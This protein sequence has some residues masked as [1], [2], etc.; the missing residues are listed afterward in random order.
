MR[1]FIF[2]I[3]TLIFSSCQK[4]DSIR[5]TINPDEVISTNFIGNGV[6]WSAYP[7]ADTENAD[8]GKLMTDEKWEMNYQRLDYM[9]PRLFRVLDQAN[10]RYLVGFDNDDMP[11]LDFTTPEVKALE[12]ILDY[13]QANNITVL[14][15]EWGTPYKVHDTHLGH[16]DKFTGA[17]DPK[18][19]NSIVSYLKYLIIDRGYTCLKYY[20]LVN[21][22]NGDWATTN[23]DFVEWSEGVKLLNEAL[24]QNGL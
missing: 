4:D 22:P 20:N 16:G 24:K 10:W 17:N 2:I 7:H 14:F 13:A 5:I 12:K 1:Y 3:M 11:I 15:G 19:I 23:G 9:Q 6:Q 21:E 8:W 18:W